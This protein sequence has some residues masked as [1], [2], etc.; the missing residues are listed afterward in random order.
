VIPIIATILIILILLL[1][2]PVNLVFTLKKDDV[3]R[4]RIVV[5]WLF[6]LTHTT[7]RPGRERRRRRSKRR[8]SLRKSIVPVGRQLIRRRRQLLSVL[9]SEGFVKRVIFLVRDLF[10]SLRPR[11][12]QLQCVMG[13]DDPADTGRVMGILAPLRV[14]ARKMTFGRDSNLNIQVIPDFSGPRFKGHCCASVQFIPLRLIGI[15]LGFFFSP[16]VLRAAGVL[17]HRSNA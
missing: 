4:G 12:F 14:F 9:R 13:L 1:A 10:Q 8:R 16:A 2:I 17:M 3:W 7:I 5:Y 6:G 11:R 15:F